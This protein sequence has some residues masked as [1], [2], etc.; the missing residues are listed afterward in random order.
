VEE[1]WGLSQE[2]Y[3]ELQEEVVGLLSHLIQ[4]DT[5]NPPGNVATAAKIL[6]DYFRA[7]GLETTL[8][9]E[10]LE[11]MN[12]VTR[13]R[14][15]G[16]GPS[17][18]MLGHLDVVPAD[19]EEWTEPPFSGL[20]KD[21]FVWGRGA[22][23]MK[24][25]VA[26]QAVALVRLARR[27]AAGEGSHGDVIFAATAD[28]EGGD[29]CGAL[30]LSENHRDLVCADFVINE[31]GRADFVINEG[32]TETTEIGT[33]RFLSIHAGEKGYASCRIVVRGH[34]GHGSVPLHH[35]SAMQGLAQILIALERY[36]PEVLTAQIPAAFIDNAVAD[37]RLR[38]R[39]KDP[40]TARAAVRELAAYDIP[41]AEV[42]EPLLG[43]TFSPTIVRAGGDAVNV[44]PSHAEVIVDCR[45]LPGQSKDDIRREI[46]R[47][48]ADVAA[49]WEMELL[50]FVPG[51]ESAAQT[52]LRDAISE[53]I[54]EFIPDTKVICEHSAAFTDSTHLR[55]AFP[56]S[57]VYGFCPFIYEIGADTAPRVHNVDERIA[58][59]DLV[60]QVLF[61]ERLARKLLS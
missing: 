39:L 16:R 37:R 55:N 14:S 52:P 32:D 59:R 7:N 19:A 25:Q 24:N 27:A 54:N 17:L 20:V 3:A 50:T 49:P 11:L 22:L 30:W 46:S 31:G 60:F 38:I 9:G 41:T 29:H 18:L 61:S 10:S 57:V 15:E 6:Q 44:I 33:Q 13:L 48:L 5:S 43:L 34:A 45:I 1:N 58:V 53:V 26:A 36:E 2:Q 56:D 21:G 4:A 12:C 23:D 51:N 28:E 35:D 8:V 40:A 47:A 42:I